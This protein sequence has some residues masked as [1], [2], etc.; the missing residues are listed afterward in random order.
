MVLFLGIF[1]ERRFAFMVM[2]AAVG[3]LSEIIPVFAID[4]IHDW[5]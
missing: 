1:L 5:L 4:N 2:H 3:L